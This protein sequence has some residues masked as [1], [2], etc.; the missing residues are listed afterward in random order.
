MA[1]KK[2][3]D[4]EQICAAGLTGYMASRLVCPSSRVPFKWP[5]DWMAPQ[6]SAWDGTALYYDQKS[7]TQLV[8][9]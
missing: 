4:A 6:Y 7:K 5:P 8:P 2:K 1:L 9:N 3:S